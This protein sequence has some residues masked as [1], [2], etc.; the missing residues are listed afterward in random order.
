MMGYGSHELTMNTLEAAV[1]ISDYLVGNRF[2]AA[3]VYVGCQIGY[4]MQ[5]GMIEK[6]PVFEAYWARLSARPA[7][8]RANELDDK[9]AATMAPP[10]S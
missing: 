3:D 4:G 6:R 7:A 8:K 9:A 2:S 1:A 5:F 10:K